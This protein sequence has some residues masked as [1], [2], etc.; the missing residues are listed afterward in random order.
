MDLHHASGNQTIFGAPDGYVRS[1]FLLPYYA[2]STDKPYAELHAQHHLEGWL[3]DKIPLIRKLNWKEVFG[4]NLYYADQTSRDPLFTEKLPYWEL[5]W[6]FENI[7][8][9]AIRPL[10]VDVVFGFF[11]KD[12]YHTGVILGV[13]L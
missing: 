5:N 2:Y 1:F 6:G 8:F 9:K 4:V 10:R 3:L 11:N 7:G 13:D 12:Y